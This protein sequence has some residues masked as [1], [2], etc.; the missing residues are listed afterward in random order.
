MAAAIVPSAG[1]AATAEELAAQIAQLQTQLASL[2]GQLGTTTTTTG[3]TSSTA[4]AACAGI[5][6]TRNLTLGSQGTDVQCLQALLNQDPATQVAASGVG[7]AAMNLSI[8]GGL[9]KSRGG[10]VSKQIRRGNFGSGRF[11]RGHR[12]CGR[13]PLARN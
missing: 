8:F 1:Q 7:S 12:F 9:T 2:M 11:D 4:P 13:G 6:F 5:S 10:G 3:T